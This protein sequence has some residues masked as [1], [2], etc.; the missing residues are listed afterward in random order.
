MLTSRYAAVFGILLSFSGLAKATSNFN[1]SG[2]FSQDD[3]QAAFEITLLSPQVITIFTTSYASGGFAPVLSL[4][5]PPASGDPN[6][7]AYNDGGSPCGTRATNPTTG[8]CLDA[9]LGYDSVLSTNPLGT[10]AAGTYLLVLT[11][12]LNTPN[13]PDLN[14]GFAFDGAGNFT[15][16]P[17]LNDGPF[18]DPANSL[19]NDT[20]NWALQINNVDAA[21][22]LPE[23]S[24]LSMMFGALAL[25]AG[26]RIFR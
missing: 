3:N 5:G 23:L 26:I 20:G 19:I 11:E 24:T 17:G 13:G 6:L 4:F 25:L 12:Q 7:F 21:V 14:S 2:T 22:A 1:F 8:V 15:A 10:L 18:V 9:L 16:I